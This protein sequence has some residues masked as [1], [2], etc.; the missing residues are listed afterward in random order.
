MRNPRAADRAAPV[1]SAAGA[2]PV[3]ATAEIPS[4]MDALRDRGAS[5]RD[6]A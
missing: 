6:S 1:Q 5:K 4:G 3:P 2:W